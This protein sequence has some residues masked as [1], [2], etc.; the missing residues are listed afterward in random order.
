MKDKILTVTL[1]PCIDKTIEITDFKKGEV[2]RIKNLRTDAGGKGI[3]ASRVLSDSDIETI[4]LSIVGGKTGELLEEL[5][6]K[7]NVKLDFLKITGE[8]R[9]NYKIYD[10]VTLETTDINESGI[11]INE[12]ILN[13][14]YQLLIK[15]L[16]STSVLILAGSVPP[17]C[18]KTVYSDITTLAKE[19]DVKV[20]VDADGE[21]LKYAI[22]SKPYAI[23]P[24]IHELENLLSKEL[25]SEEEIIKSIHE[26]SNNGISLVC[27][28]MGKDGAYFYKDGQ[29]IKTKPIK[30]NVKSAVGC[31]DSMVASIAYSIVHSYGLDTTAKIATAAG[32]LTAAKDGTNTCNIDE[33]VDKSKEVEAKIIE[34]FEL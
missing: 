31:G 33:A 5:L 14:F 6:I 8:T 22:D 9:T 34:I 7:E 28:S 21:L 13:E 18:K 25:N 16:P 11:N 19:Y 29:M 1:N 24:N 2:N 20:I 17:G 4:A 26:L 10:P 32:S 15:Y 30:V 3:N 23:K 12:D 27:V